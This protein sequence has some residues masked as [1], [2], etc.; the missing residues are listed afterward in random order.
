MTYSISEA[1]AAFKATGSDM[2][3]QA[4]LTLNGDTLT[5]YGPGSYPKDAVAIWTFD[6]ETGSTAENLAK[7]P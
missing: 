6:D 4:T 3:S 2:L 5:V 1:N 7:L